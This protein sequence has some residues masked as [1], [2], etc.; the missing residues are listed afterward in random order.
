MANSERSNGPAVLLRVGFD[1]ASAQGQSME[2][3]ALRPKLEH[4]H[5]PKCLPVENCPMLCGRDRPRIGPVGGELDN[6][7]LDLASFRGYRIL[8]GTSLLGGRTRVT[9]LAVGVLRPAPVS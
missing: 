6:S 7:A 5:R 8:H 9:A 4:G 1:R 2:G 3:T